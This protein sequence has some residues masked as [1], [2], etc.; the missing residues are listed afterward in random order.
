MSNQRLE[1][2]TKK[3]IHPP[4]EMVVDGKTYPNNP[5]SNALFDEL[6]KHEKAALGGDINALYAQVRILYNIPIVVLKKLDMRDIRTL[7]EFTMTKAFGSKEE[8][9]EPEK[10][11]K[12]G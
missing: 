8:Q 1:L 2:S 3:S 10:E 6:K 5:L 4:I 7:L 11:E 12:K 9:T